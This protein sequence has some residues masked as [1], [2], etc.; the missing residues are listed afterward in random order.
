MKKSIVRKGLVFAVIILFVL[1]SNQSIAEEKLDGIY[2]NIG[3][4]F[5]MK[6]EDNKESPNLEGD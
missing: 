5:Y 2:Y 6:N 3:E 4:V 1:Y